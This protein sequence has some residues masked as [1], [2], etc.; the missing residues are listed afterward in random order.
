MTIN[1][2]ATKCLEDMTPDKIKKMPKI[3]H[4]AY[5]LLKAMKDTLRYKNIQITDYQKTLTTETQFGAITF[6]FNNWVYIA[7]EGTNDYISGWQEDCYLSY[8]YPIPGQI[9]ASEYINK[10]IK[11]TD[12]VI[13]IGGHSKGGNLAVAG[14]MKASPSIK[15]R[16]T[17]I[18]D[19]DGPGMREKEFNSYEYKTIEPKIKKYVPN[20]S[21]I[22]MLMYSPLNF[23]TVTSTAKSIFQHNQYTWSCFGDFFVEGSISR[24]SLRLSREIKKFVKEYAEEDMEEFVSKVFTA[25]K[26]SGLNTVD[27]Y[28]VTSIAKCMSHIT[29]LKTDQKTKEKAL[30]LFSILIAF[31]R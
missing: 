18:Y 6:R 7:F 4:G 28:S 19:F 29:D 31:H 1:D 24:K 11:I 9:S 10:N 27:I 23:K 25:I 16:I 22:G 17:A 2:V 30:K 5:N 15:R 3:Y 20:N 13:Y 12:R 21:I 8:Q 14:A 26:K